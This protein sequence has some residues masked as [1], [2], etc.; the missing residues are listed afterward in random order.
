MD[1][2]ARGTIQEQ[3]R[4]IAWLRATGPN[5]FEYFIWAD[6]TEAIV[7]QIFGA[8]SPEATVFGEAVYRRGRTID[9]RGLFDNMTLGL[10]GEWGIWARLD[11]AQGV[12]EQILSRYEANAGS[13]T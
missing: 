12:L 9:Q 10:H 6:T 11:R 8:T 13:A 3:L 1:E 4:R 7:R 2:R 5:P